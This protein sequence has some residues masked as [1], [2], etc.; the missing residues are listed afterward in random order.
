MLS[1][2]V[3]ANGTET[4]LVVSDDGWTTS[5]A[6]T[7]ATVELDGGETLTIPANSFQ[8]P[9]F[10]T[11]DTKAGEVVYLGVAV[12]GKTVTLNGSA[13]IALSDLAAPV[14]VNGTCVAVSANES[15]TLDLSVTAYASSA[16]KVASSA[17][18]GITGY[19]KAGL[20]VASTSTKISF[21]TAV[22]V[23]FANGVTL[24]EDPLGVDLGGQ[25]SLLGAADSKGKQK[26]L[27]KGDF[28]GS[29][30]R[31]SDGELTLGGVDKNVIDAKGDILIGGEPI[32]FELTDAD[33]DGVIE[34][35]PAVLLRVYSDGKG[36]RAVAT[37]NTGNPGLL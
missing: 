21:E 15:G 33:K 26:T 4:F 13:T 7:H 2:Q 34:A 10:A 16:A 9:G 23:V 14:C 28:Y 20:K 11:V 29:F 8:R 5:S 36:T 31:A 24:A 12:D 30:V 27:A 22:G 25:V 37:S 1:D 17:T 19:D 35:P 18:I 32:D 3:H 6:P